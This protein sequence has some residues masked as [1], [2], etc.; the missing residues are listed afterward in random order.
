MDEEIMPGELVYELADYQSAARTYR[1]DLLRLPILSLDDEL[2]HMTLRPGVRY[3]EVVGTTDLDVELQPYVRNARQ[4]VDLELGLREL[5]TYFGTVNADF[6]PNKNISTLMGHRASQAMGDAL[7]TTPQAHEVLALVPKKIGKKLKTALFKAVRNAKGKTTNDLFDGFDTIAEREIAAG[8]ISAALGNYIKLSGKPDKFNTLE[9]CQEILDAM[10]P[11]L[12][13][14]DCTMYVPQTFLDN[15]NRSYKLDGGA[16]VYKD[17]YDQTFVEGSQG[18]LRIVPLV[19][20]AG[21][22][23]IQI[24]PESNMLVGC[25]QLSDKESVRVANYEPDTF[26]LMMRMFFGCEYESI[27]PRRLLIAEIPA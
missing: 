9:L 6:D 11:E 20:K 25:D 10:S 26:T 17:K 2:A 24:C 5:R 21:S 8:N 1:S 4:K 22:N 12:R 18:R 27:D 15:Y 7:A 23:I 16:L 19:G 13:A 3:S 14:E